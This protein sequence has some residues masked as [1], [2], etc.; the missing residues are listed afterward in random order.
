MSPAT[1]SSA[2]PR[3]NLAL[4]GGGAHGAFTWG[5][6]DRLLEDGRIEFAG[7]S[8]HQRRGHERGSTGLRHGRGG[9]AEARATLRA[10]GRCWRAGPLQPAAADPAR[11]ARVS[12]ATWITRPAGSSSTRCRAWSRP[13]S[14]SDQLQPAGRS[15]GRRWSTSPGCASTTHPVVRLRHQRQDRQDP[16]VRLPRDLGRRP[17][18]RRRACRSSPGGRDRRRGLLGRRLHGQSR[19]ST[20]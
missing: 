4:Q 9:A 13:T 20:R 8:R 14:Q 5:V 11:P 6:L 19:R 17:F 12:S 3:V 18:W 7:I 2:R 16:G 1:A 10:S 15:A